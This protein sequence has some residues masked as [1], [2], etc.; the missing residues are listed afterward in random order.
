MV[1]PVA[2]RNLRTCR[3]TPAYREQAPRPLRDRFPIRWKQ[4]RDS[5]PRRFLG[6]C[7]FRDRWHKPLAHPAVNQNLHT[8]HV[9]C[10][11]GVAAL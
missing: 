9:R 1:S 2:G 6:P 4:E 8:E 7:D 10:C 11:S 5:D 3:S